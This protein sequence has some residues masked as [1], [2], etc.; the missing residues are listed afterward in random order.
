MTRKVSV[1]DYLSMKKENGGGV[2]IDMDN[3]ETIRDEFAMM[4]DEKSNRML[5]KQLA[6][7]LNILD[8]DQNLD[9]LRLCVDED[10]SKN[11]KTEIC[12]KYYDDQQRSAPTKTKETSAKPT[13][14]TTIDEI[15]CQIQMK[16]NHDELNKFFKHFLLRSISSE[17]FEYQI[18]SFISFCLDRQ[19]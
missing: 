1:Y 16:A 2:S 5:L 14:T 13:T 3:L 6:Q 9:L 18:S 11:V 12:Q 8:D 4:T 7:K 10:S 17:Y 15:N 19:C